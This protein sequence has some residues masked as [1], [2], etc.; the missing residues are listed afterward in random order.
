MVWILRKIETLWENNS[1]EFL[2]LRMQSFQGI[3]FV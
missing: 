1:L 2:K 3:I